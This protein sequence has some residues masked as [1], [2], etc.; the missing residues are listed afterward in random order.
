MERANKIALLNMVTYKYAPYPSKKDSLANE[1]E[2]AKQTTDCF[3][4][5]SEK[6]FQA[7]QN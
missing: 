7:M 1:L 3:T 4:K 5:T 2:Y 6:Y